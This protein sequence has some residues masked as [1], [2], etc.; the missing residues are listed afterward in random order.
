M[1]NFDFTYFLFILGFFLIVVLIG[2]KLA[3]HDRDIKQETISEMEDSIS[4]AYSDGYNDGY[5]D[6]YAAA[7]AGK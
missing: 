5:N 4:A 1:K 7:L 6:G 3:D 2:F